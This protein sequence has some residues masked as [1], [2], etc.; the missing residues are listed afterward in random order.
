L[1]EL[2]ALR[3][4]SEMPLDELLQSLP[5][6]MFNATVEDEDVGSADQKVQCV[7]VLSFCFVKGKGKGQVLAITLL[8]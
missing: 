1:A 7:S 8:A 5:A 6:E 2:E 4:E 3:Q